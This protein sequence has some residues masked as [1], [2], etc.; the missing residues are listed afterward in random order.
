MR[1]LL[2]KEAL[3][4]AIIKTKSIIEQELR[5]ME[6]LYRE[7]YIPANE[8]ISHLANKEIA[9][10]EEVLQ[11]FHASE[12]IENLKRITSDAN[13]RI[14]DAINKLYFAL[15]PLKHWNF[16]QIHTDNFIISFEELEKK[17]RIE[18]FSKP[19]HLLYLRV[20]CI[21]R[22]AEHKLKITDALS[23]VSNLISKEALDWLRDFTFL[24]W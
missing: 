11:L 20:F 17:H 10:Y 2:T 18:I 19:D 13:S 9:S 23:D 1:N 4:E 14:V 21:H 6:E 5:H 12:K 15:L 24:S 7:I 3:E 16:K 8:T 22:D